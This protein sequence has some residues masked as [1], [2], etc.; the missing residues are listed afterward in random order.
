MKISVSS[1]SFNQY[2]KDGRMKQLDTVRKAAEMG[3]EGIEFTDL[4]PFESPTKYDK[5]KYA[6]QIRE[7][8]DRCGIKIVAYCIGASLYCENAEENERAVASACDSVDI[9]AELGAPVMRH[10]V[11]G[12]TKFGDRTVSFDKQLP[13]IAENARRITEY[14]LSK[15]IKTCTENHGFVAQ[16]SDRVERLYNAVG[17]DNYGLL[18]DIGNF[19][20]AD[21]DSVKAVSRVAPYA[22]HVHVKDFYINRFGEEACFKGGFLSR[23]CNTLLGSV[24]G[25]GDIPTAQCIAILK[26]AGYNGFVSIEY[27]GAEDCM[28]GLCR[29]IINLRRYIGE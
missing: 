9:A 18:V 16:D 23:G 25:E 8:A 12:K 27:E 15:G 21:E 7:E 28:K 4:V 11:T 20:C 29:G 19:A 24:I 3:F 14:A 17:H 1:Y 10:D 2:L 26:K 6:S 13:T 5:M 22:V